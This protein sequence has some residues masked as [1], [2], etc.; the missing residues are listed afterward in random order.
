MVHDDDFT[1]TG[2]GVEVGGGIHEW[3]VRGEGPR[4]WALTM[5]GVGSFVRG[6]PEVQ[7]RQCWRL[8]IYRRTR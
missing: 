7:G 4:A 2:D 1:F 5:G 8:W 6:E 3:V